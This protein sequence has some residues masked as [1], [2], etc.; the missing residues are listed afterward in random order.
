EIFG[1][2]AFEEYY[3]NFEYIFNSYSLGLEEIFI[4]RENDKVQRVHK[5]SLKFVDLAID[6]LRDCYISH[7]T[8]VHDE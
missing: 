7:L 3:I 8:G 1:K 2:E 4:D 5:H 6:N